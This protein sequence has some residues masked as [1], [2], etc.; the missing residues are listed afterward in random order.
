MS[1]SATEP[2]VVRI[3]PL[4][5]AAIR[6][7]LD[8]E[9]ASFPR[10][11]S[12]DALAAELAR[13]DRCYLAAVGPATGDI[14]GYAGLAVQADVAHVMI[15]AVDPGSRGRGVGTLLVGA[16]VDEAVARGAAA[17]TLEVAEANAAAR[18]VYRR[19]GFRDEGV[20]RGYY[21]DG[22]DAVLMWWRPGG[23]R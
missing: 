10:P 12:A 22:D 3:V 19:H 16:L 7:I 17:V 14:V 8:I 11:W 20:R 1:A 21:P 5:T 6:R 13:D 9:E 4:E 2:V 15:L 18:R 23:G